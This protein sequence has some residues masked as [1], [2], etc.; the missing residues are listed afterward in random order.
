MKF[1]AS[2]HSA[3][4]GNLVEELV[5][6]ALIDRPGQ[7]EQHV[8]LFIGQMQRCGHGRVPGGRATMTS[9]ALRL[10]G[11]GEGG[12]KSPV[13]PEPDHVDPQ[14]EPARERWL[15]PLSSYDRRESSWIHGA[16]FG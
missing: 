14:P 1:L 13:A 11:A 5:A 7:L 9:S 12:A 15:K 3:L 2:S 8:H 6:L 16:R 4:S 10:Q